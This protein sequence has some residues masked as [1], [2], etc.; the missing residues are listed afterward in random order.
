ML[1]EYVSNRKND[2]YLSIKTGDALAECFN[3]EISSYEKLLGIQRIKERNSKTGLVGT[4]IIPAGHRY[5]E[6]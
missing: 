3:Q 5:Y 1:R 2:P 6:K 4:T